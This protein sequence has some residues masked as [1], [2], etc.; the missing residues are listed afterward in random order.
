MSVSRQMDDDRTA[1][2]DFEV[3]H[4]SVNVDNTGGPDEQ[5]EAVYEIEPVSGDLDNDEI[6]ELVM[7]HR[8]YSMRA[9]ES[10]SDNQAFVGFSQGEMG[11]AL[12]T[13]NRDQ[14]LLNKTG[15]NEG[16]ITVVDTENEDSLNAD[17]SELDEPE[18]LDYAAFALTPGFIDDTNEDAGGPGT[19]S[20]DEQRTVNF[21]DNF[22]HGPFVDRTDDVNI[23]VEVAKQDVTPTV[24]ANVSV[25]LIWDVTRIENTRGTLAPPT[26]D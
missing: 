7:I 22:G 25:T 4:V 19:G 18:Q 11:L 26:D 1:Y 17:G 16:Q 14:F 21:R 15:N 10:A 2:S 24:R 13:P 23:F 9:D 12:N 6:A 5:V 20:K 8:D 3:Q